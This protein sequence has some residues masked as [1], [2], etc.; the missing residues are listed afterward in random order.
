VLLPNN[1]TNDTQTCGLFSNGHITASLTNSTSSFVVSE[2]NHLW[3][4]MVT[5]ICRS[6]PNDS[7]LQ[8]CHIETKNNPP[9][10]VKQADTYGFL[11]GFHWADYVTNLFTVW[12]W[13]G[14]S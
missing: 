6:Q 14:H 10:E 2:V 4:L 5:P 3:Q 7:H 13:G 9:T 12:Q 11:P 1:K 8:I